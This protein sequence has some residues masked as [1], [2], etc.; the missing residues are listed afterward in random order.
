MCVSTYS[1]FP[2]RHSAT[3]GKTIR[4][5]IWRANIRLMLWQLWMLQ[6]WFTICIHI[7]EFRYLAGGWLV[8][9]PSI[10]IYNSSIYIRLLTTHTHIYRF[11]GVIKQ[12]QKL[13]H[14]LGLYHTAEQQR[15]TIPM[16]H[17][18]PPTHF[19]HPHSLDTFILCRF[20]WCFCSFF[21]FTSSASFRFISNVLVCSCV[22][23]GRN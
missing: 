11:T 14:P 4:F 19:N 13:A 21:F 23:C 2:H 15:F 12:T 20:A 7:F 9:P 5:A 22:L 18:S 16:E 1:T 17:A 3:F 10:D 6:T 8:S